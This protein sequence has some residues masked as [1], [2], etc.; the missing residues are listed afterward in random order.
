ML[1]RWIIAML[2]SLLLALTACGQQSI[3]PE[4]V[5]TEPVIP[6]QTEE[7]TVPVQ[8]LPTEGDV[9]RLTWNTGNRILLLESHGV[10]VYLCKTSDWGNIVYDIQIKN[11]STIPVELWVTDVIYNDR[12][13]SSNYRYISAEPGAWGGDISPLSLPVAAA[14]GEMDKVQRLDFQLKLLDDT[15][16]SVLMEQAVQVNLEETAALKAFYMDADQLIVTEPFMEFF[17][18]DE[19]LLL[20]K[21]GVRVSLL[22]IGQAANFASLTYVYRV[23]NTA[24]DW[25][26]FV[27]N[28][29]A[30]NDVYIPGDVSSVN[31]QPGA[32]SYG[33]VHISDTYGM[34]RIGSVKLGLGTGEGKMDSN[35]P[36]EIAWCAVAPKSAAAEPTP[37]AEGDQLLLEEQGLRVT[38]KK[39]EVD[40]G[41]NP[42][43]TLIV[44]NTTDQNISLWLTDPVSGAS[45]GSGRVGAGQRTVVTVEGDGDQPVSCCL[46]AWDFTGHYVLF[47]C[48]GRMELTLSDHIA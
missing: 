3:P 24:D 37:L 23:E 36:A 5:A 45:L 10:S 1:K 12:I 26:H 34:E 35:N 28:G 19:Q 42:V 8:Q 7:T 16:Q 33:Y 25:R 2:A 46:Q 38:L 11:D 21:D 15:T 17:A 29:T 32:L 30:I 48:Q 27:H 47:E 20:E 6:S 44:V 9:L 18:P 22:G 13:M 4:T 43:W 39:E 40:Y 31:L 41:G 14:V